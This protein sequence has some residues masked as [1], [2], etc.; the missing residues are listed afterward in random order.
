[1]VTITLKGSKNLKEKL[2]SMGARLE[3]EVSKAVVGTALEIEKTAKD[4]IKNPGKG[5]MYY[6]IYDAES[7]YTTIFAGDSEGYV[8]SI[9]GKLNLSATH[10]ASA[11]GDPPATDTGRLL[12]SIRFDLVN[13]LTATVGSNV[14][15][16][17][18]L[19]YGTLTMAARPF[20]RPAAELSRPKFAKRVAAAI[21]RATQ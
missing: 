18:W 8:T 17:A 1:M 5:T 9:K 11:P 12:N 20:M 7:G 15:Y 4:S 14:E 16:A 10:R 13:K 3:E 19:E 2:S 6:R 21:R